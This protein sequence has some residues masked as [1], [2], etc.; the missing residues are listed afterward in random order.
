MCS[1][2]DIVHVMPRIQPNPRRT[3][4]LHEAP[5]VL[6]LLELEIVLIGDYCYPHCFLDFTGKFFFLKGTSF[7]QVPCPFGGR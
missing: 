3:Y 4:S 1:L 2:S 6:V 5:K 7:A